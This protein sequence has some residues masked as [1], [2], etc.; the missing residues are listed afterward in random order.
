MK[1]IILVLMM[2][3]LP[4]MIINKEQKVVI[5]NRTKQFKILINQIIKK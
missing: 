3:I 2:K 1:E 4:K 5:Q